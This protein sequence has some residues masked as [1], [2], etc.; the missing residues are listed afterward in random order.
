[1]GFVFYK[2]VHSNLLSLQQW[3]LA[4]GNKGRPKQIGKYFG[5][6]KLTGRANWCEIGSCSSA[7]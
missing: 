4:S 2:V 6:V 3:H 7:H 1:M 5:A